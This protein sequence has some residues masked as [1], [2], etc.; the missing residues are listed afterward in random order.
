MATTQYSNLGDLLK[1]VY[2]PWE[3]EMLVNLHARAIEKLAKKGNAMLGGNGFFGAVRSRSAEG[4]GFIDEVGDLPTAQ[5]TTVNQWVV[6]PKIF[7]G[8]VDLSGLS[9]RLTAGNAMAFA[10]AFDE[11]VQNTLESMAMYKEGAFCRDGTGQLATATAD[12]GASAGPWTF[13]DVGFLREG[14]DVVFYDVSTAGGAETYFGPYTIDVV[15]WVNKQVTFS[16][17]V[18]ATVTTGDILYLRDTQGPSGTAP[19]AREPGGVK[20]MFASSGTYAG[21]SRTTIANWRSSVMAVSDLLDEQYLLRMRTRIQQESGIQIQSMAGAFNLFCH[22]MQADIL[23]RLAL[24]RIRYAGTD[25]IDLGNSD[26][27]KFGNIGIVTS[28]QHDPTQAELGDWRHVKSLYTEGGEL[29]VDS[30][31][32]GSTLKWVSNKDVAR[33]IMLSYCEWISPFPVGFGRMTGLTEQ[34]R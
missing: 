22:P 30:E 7:A 10:G 28:T 13:D 20:A 34:S 21:L 11:E 19:V 4:I 16:S 33:V 5:K 1:N 24:P 26:D 18:D 31:M 27:V 29:H 3:I 9:R 2:A 8:V 23:F 15:D 6:R 14:M 32:N 25:M 12:A 17:A